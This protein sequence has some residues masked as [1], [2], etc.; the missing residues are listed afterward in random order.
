[1]PGALATRR[2]DDQF[3]TQP[4]CHLTVERPIMTMPLR[5]GNPAGAGGP[6]TGHSMRDWLT[7]PSERTPWQPWCS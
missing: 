6:G 3:G 7:R 2:H 1:M 4:K 5:A